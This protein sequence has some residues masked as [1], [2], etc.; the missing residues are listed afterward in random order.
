[1]SGAGIM[2]DSRWQGM[3]ER[4][5]DEAVELGRSANE[6]IDRHVATC[7][8]SNI[9]Q[10]KMQRLIF[11]LQLVGFALLTG[12]VLGSQHPL[13]KAIISAGHVP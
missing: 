8:A 10:A 7:E 13:V 5:L 3:I 1:M 11:R 2:V 9:E 6:K 12:A 4:G